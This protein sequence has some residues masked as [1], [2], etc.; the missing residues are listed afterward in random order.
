MTAKDFLLT[1]PGDI[2]DMYSPLDWNIS[3]A[4]CLRRGHII[5]LYVKMTNVNAITVGVTGNITDIS[6]G[7]L[8]SGLIPIL[9]TT[10]HSYGNY[11]GQQWYYINTAGRIWL[12][13]VEGTGSSR[14]IDAGTQFEILAVYI[15][16]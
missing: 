14:T 8:K 5:Q 7:Y 15:I 13:A 6:V 2:F 3:E 1:D 4:K 12:T 11:A 10:A 16:D 9:P